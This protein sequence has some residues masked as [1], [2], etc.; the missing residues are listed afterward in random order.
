M[1]PSLTLTSASNQSFPYFPQHLRLSCITISDD[2]F[3]KQF[4]NLNLWS[5][6]NTKKPVLEMPT[7]ILV[8]HQ[9]LGLSRGKMNTC[10]N[11]SILLIRAFNRE[12]ERFTLC[13]GAGGEKREAC[14]EPGE[15]PK[16]RR[17][18]FIFRC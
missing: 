3:V 14:S 9:T 7:Q 17:P 1:P 11:H 15:K 5:C 4:N 18:F 16:G 13:L 8:S 2:H 12:R 6:R 10:L